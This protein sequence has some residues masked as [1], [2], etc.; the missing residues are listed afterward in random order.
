MLGMTSGNEEKLDTLNFR[1]HAPSTNI[2]SWG[3]EYLRHLA[4]EIGKDYQRRAEKE[5][6]VTELRDLA[7]VLVP[8]FLSQSAEPDAVDLLCEVEAIDQLPNLL[9]ENTYPKACLYMSR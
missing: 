1:L 4:L 5:E 8:F 2:G 6:D 9:D 3:H 7:L